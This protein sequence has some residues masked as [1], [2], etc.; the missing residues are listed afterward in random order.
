MNSSESLL[1]QNM[2]DAF[3]NIWLWIPLAIIVFYVLIN[4]NSW[5]RIVINLFSFLSILILSI[6][7][8]RFWGEEKNKF[9]SIFL[10]IVLTALP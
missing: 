8:E 3:I 1:L 2:K 9:I 10:Q 6:W 4:N 7:I 5:K